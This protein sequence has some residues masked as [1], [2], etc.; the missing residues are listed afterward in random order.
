MKL[1]I[2]LLGGILV[3]SS[4]GFVPPSSNKETSSSKLLD[5]PSKLS[6][7][8]TFPNWLVENANAASTS[9][10]DLRGFK[11]TLSSQA[12]VT[13]VQGGNVEE[14]VNKILSSELFHLDP[15]TWKL[16]I[17]EE[18]VNKMLS[19][20]FFHLAAT[21]WHLEAIAAFGVGSALLW[22]VTTPES[23]DDAPYEPGTSTYSPE[24]AAEFYAKRPLQ[25]VKR[26]LK[27]AFLTGMFNAGILF[28]WLVLGK[29]LKDEEY[30]ALRRNEPRRAKVALSLCEKLG[31]TFIKLGQALSIRTDLIPEAYAL[32]L[33]QLQDAVPPFDSDVAREVLKKELGVS[34]L[35]LIFSSLSDKPVASASIGQVYKGTLASTGKEVAVKVS[36]FPM[37]T[38]VCGL[39]L[40]ILHR[41][42]GRVFSQRLPSIFMC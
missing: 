11:D 35:S 2:G 28:D 41:F 22:F 27:L 15:T 13:G 6:F 33:R 38:I 31:P 39:S 8:V 40:I 12:S 30:T 9:L 34:D 4:S 19:S 26:V 16:P 21:S 20:E 10:N 32:E 5:I 1:S 36:K 37:T 18:T 23:F 14:A 42:K 3:G 7:E 17:P 24:K 29:L 25:V